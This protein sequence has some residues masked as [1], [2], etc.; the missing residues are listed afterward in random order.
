[1][2]AGP[3]SRGSLWPRGA[4]GALDPGE[5]W[6]HRDSVDGW[7]R[8]THALT[9]ESRIWVE[10]LDPAAAGN[11]REEEVAMDASRSRKVRRILR[12]DAHAR[13]V[14]AR[15]ERARARVTCLQRRVTAYLTEARL[16]EASLTGG[17]L[18]ELRRARANGTVPNTTGEEGSRCRA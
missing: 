14:Q 2:R 15:L 12:L 18:G 17:Q 5:P 3:T 7:H 6:Q 8:F 11:G 1:M 4:R 16:L 9:G 10:R 13:R